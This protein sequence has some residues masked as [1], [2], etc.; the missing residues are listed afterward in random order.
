MKTKVTLTIEASII[1]EAKIQKINISSAAEDGISAFLGQAR[2]GKVQRGENGEFF[3]SEEV[4]KELET[5]YGEFKL[6]MSRVGARY[7][8]RKGSIWI[9]ERA[10]SVGMDPKELLGIFEKRYSKDLADFAKTPK[11]EFSEEATNNLISIFCSSFSIFIDNL[12]RRYVT[13]D[14][15]TENIIRSKIEDASKSWVDARRK[16]LPSITRKELYVILKN[17]YN[18]KEGKIKL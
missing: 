9:F 4:Q 8:N 12:H 14:D 17:Y 2:H 13:M 18:E 16:K 7:D 6:Y 10:V 1:E 11:I 15:M 3:M 5:A